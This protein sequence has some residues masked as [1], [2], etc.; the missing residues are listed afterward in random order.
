M[1]TNRYGIGGSLVR[2]KR[3]YVVTAECRVRIGFH[4]RD[5]EDAEDQFNDYLADL[6]GAHPE[7]VLD[8]QD[9]R[10][11]DALF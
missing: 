7:V 9:I 5:A 3:D 8:I 6:Q 2:R 11:D 10:E 1:S 4:A